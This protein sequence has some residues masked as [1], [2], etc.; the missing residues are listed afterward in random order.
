MIARAESNASAGCATGVNSL[1]LGLGQAAE[2]V[3]DKER[4]YLRPLATHN[5]LAKHLGGPVALVGNAIRSI[6]RRRTTPFTCRGGRSGDVE[7]RKP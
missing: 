7:P 2:S 3:E 6:L 1:G 4:Q 5:E